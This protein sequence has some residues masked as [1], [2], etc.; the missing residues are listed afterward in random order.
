MDRPVRFLR[1]P[2]FE[3]ALGSYCGSGAAHAYK[4]HFHEEI[5]LGANL[6][7]GEWLK[8]DRRDYV[9]DQGET[10]LYNPAQV[11]EGGSL[12]PGRDW[13]FLTFYVDAQTAHQILYGVDGFVEFDAAVL[14]CEQTFGLF[15]EGERH[16]LAGRL[17]ELD[18]VVALL[19]GQLALRVGT[20]KRG[21]KIEPG[22]ATADRRIRRVAEHLLGTLDTPPELAQLA[23]E[24]GIST[25]HLVRSFSRTFGLPPMAW[26]MQMRLARARRLLRDGVTPAHVAAD[27]GFADQSHLNRF[28]KRV[29]GV[30][31]A[32]FSRALG[33]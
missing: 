8:L 15:L 9:A 23:S 4:R 28:F 3:A 20:V 16:F 17:E 32:R 14:S 26:A 2:L 5:V 1:R 13:R 6:A 12:D 33:R 7:A 30:T 25:E 27:L 24:A 11:Q 19:L 29:S 18:E 21:K 31:P 10:T 22:L